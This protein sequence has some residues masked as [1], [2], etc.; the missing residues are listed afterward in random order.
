M[1]NWTEDFGEYPY[2]HCWLGYIGKDILVAE[3]NNRHEMCFLLSPL[4]VQTYSSLKAAKIGT[5]RRLRAWLK[6]AGLEVK[7]G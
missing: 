1:I 4:H 2:E 3:I 5:E 6:D 7:D